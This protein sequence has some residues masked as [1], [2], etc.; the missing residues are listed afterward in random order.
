M[1]AGRRRA[2][3]TAGCAASL[4]ASKRF[5]GRR[6]GLLLAD[7]VAP[8][9]RIADALDGWRAEPAQLQPRLAL[10]LADLEDAAV[11]R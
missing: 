2:H 11:G 9:L 6:R 3:T 7:G 10:Y 5:R 1:S 8:R 4:R